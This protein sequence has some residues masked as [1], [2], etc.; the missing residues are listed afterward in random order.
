MNWRPIEEM[1][2]EWKDD[3]RVV[4]LGNRDYGAYS[5]AVWRDKWVRNFDHGTAIEPTHYAADFA[6]IP[7]EVEITT[8]SDAECVHLDLVTG[9]ERREPFEASSL[10]AALDRLE[11][12]VREAVKQMQEN[13]ATLLEIEQNTR[14]IGEMKA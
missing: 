8:F 2:A 14:H 13:P 12:D 4:L 6:P 9:A 10:D 11:R 5:I 7:D 3:G 1:P